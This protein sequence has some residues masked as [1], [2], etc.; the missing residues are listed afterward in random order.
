MEPAHDEIRQVNIYNHIT[1]TIDLETRTDQ[2][3]TCVFTIT[4]QLFTYYR[5]CV[6]VASLDLGLIILV[7][8]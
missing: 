5:S 2:Y 7:I 3:W 4:V 1:R 8:R 6:E